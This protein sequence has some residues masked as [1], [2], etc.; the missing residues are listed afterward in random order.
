MVIV[1]QAW[2][3]ERKVPFSFLHQEVIENVNW[4]C[5][6]ITFICP[7]APTSSSNVVIQFVKGVTNFPAQFVSNVSPFFVSFLYNQ[8][9]IQLI[10]LEFLIHSYAFFLSDPRT[11]IYK[12]T[13]HFLEGSLV[14]LL[15][16][17]FLQH[18]LRWRLRDSVAIVKGFNCKSY[19]LSTSQ[20]RTEVRWKPTYGTVG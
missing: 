11:Y 19:S 17:N 12:L 20:N 9:L 1:R 4:F 15:N 3:N 14:R 7:P 13:I 16:R 6:T 8:Y 18:N 10:C 2:G 5:L